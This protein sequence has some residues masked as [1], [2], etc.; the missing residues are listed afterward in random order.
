LSETLGYQRENGGGR[1]LNQNNI[2]VER[3]AKRWK[4]KKESEI[5]EASKRKTPAGKFSDESLAERMSILKRAYSW[6]KVKGR[7]K[8]LKYGYLGKEKCQG[9]QES[10]RGPRERT[11]LEGVR[12]RDEKRPQN[13]GRQGRLKMNRTKSSRPL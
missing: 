9:V 7:K 13:G 12:R 1:E 4:E 2:M 8:D 3:E 6:S 11:K 5:M 10:S